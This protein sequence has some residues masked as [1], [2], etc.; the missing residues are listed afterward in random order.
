MS[1]SAI[2]SRNLRSLQ[3]EYLDHPGALR[4]AQALR[5]RVFAN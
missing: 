3:A 5:Y 4:E 2:P 1:V